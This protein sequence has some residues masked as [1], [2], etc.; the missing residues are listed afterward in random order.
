[1]QIKEKILQEKEIYNVV[2]EGKFLG[3]RD[4]AHVTSRLASILKT[5]AELVEMLCGGGRWLIRKGIKHVDARKY[6]ASFARAGARCS[7]EPVESRVETDSKPEKLEYSL[8]FRLYPFCPKVVAG[9]KPVPVKTGDGQDV[10]HMRARHLIFGKAFSLI[11]GAVIAAPIQMHAL[12]HLTPWL[13]P[14][15]TSQI[16]ISGYFFLIYIIFTLLIS[17]RQIIIQHEKSAE[18]TLLELRGKGYYKFGILAYRVYDAMGTSIGI[19]KRNLSG[20]DFRMLDTNGSTVFSSMRVIELDESATE[21]ML[22]LQ[23]QI[24]DSRI[25]DFLRHVTKLDFRWLFRRG[26]KQQGDKNADKA[27]IYIIRSQN[28]EILARFFLGK[29]VG[30]LM[31][32]REDYP[33]RLKIQ[34]LAHCLQISGL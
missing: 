9:P 27:R 7:I 25:I 31:M 24:A 19:M 20:T 23:G 10:F 34:L 30:V 16:A 8:S 22:E 6:E 33:E 26:R 2:F 4:E 14:R 11:F 17:R 1:M 3:D 5:D 28:D 32:P 29:D 12:P 13:G 18:K 21:A 15:V